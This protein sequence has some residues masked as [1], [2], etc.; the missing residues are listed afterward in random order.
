LAQST[1]SA[2]QV[3]GSVAR[4]RE[5]QPPSQ[6]LKAQQVWPGPPHALH[7]AAAAGMSGIIHA[8]STAAHD[9]CPASAA[10]QQGAPAPPQPE[11]LPP[12]QVP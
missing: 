10:G 12:A 11:Q 8:V 9:R 3:P 6:R 7:R 2:T 5:Q 4:A 1:P